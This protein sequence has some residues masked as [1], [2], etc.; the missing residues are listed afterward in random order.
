MSNRRGLTN[1]QRGSESSLG[2]TYEIT[3]PNAQ[4]RAIKRLEKYRLQSVARS[5]LSN[6]R[7]ASCLRFVIPHA[8]HVKIWKA[9]ERAHYSGLVVCGSVWN[10][11]VCASK[12]SER[13]RVELMQ[14]MNTWKGRGSV[15]MLVLT[16]P[17]YQHQPLHEVLDKFTKARQ[18]FR[19]RK[20]W[21][22][23]GIS[24]DLHLRGSVRALEVTHGQNG[25]HVHSHELLLCECDFSGGYG[26]F[27]A[28]IYDVWKSVCLSVGLGAPDRLH[29]VKV[30]DGSKAAS[31]ASKWGLEDEMTKAHLKAGRD[32]NLSP[33]DMLRG[34]DEGVK[35]YKALFREYARGFKGKRQL[36]W[37]DGLR[38]VLGL[39]REKSDAEIAKEIDQDAVLLGMLTRADWT[40]VR[41]ADRRGELLEIAS[42]Q[43]WDGVVKFIQCLVMKG[44]GSA[45]F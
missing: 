11:P 23:D 10:C 1:S 24:Q 13:R 36:V 41:R 26:M 22:K 18:R 32:G 19:E 2:T 16:I 31:Y 42:S 40:A 43:G 3:F 45:P 30:H 17:H 8:N 7:V 35:E 12:I 21:W 44:H 27:E 29:G 15:L 33:W 38:D 34:I 4:D 25:W 37:S 5:I 9:H 20:A 14:G 39:G 28:R 6:E